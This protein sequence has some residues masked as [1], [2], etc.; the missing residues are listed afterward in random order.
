MRD[1]REE[2]VRQLYVQPS[3]DGY[4]AVKLP[5]SKNAQG[6]PQ[7]G[8][9]DA[10]FNALKCI[11]CNSTRQN[12]FRPCGENVKAVNPHSLDTT[13][14]PGH[15]KPFLKRSLPSL[16]MKYAKNNRSHKQKMRSACVWNSGIRS[17]G[18]HQQVTA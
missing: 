5:C 10:I 3:F 14:L 9:H 1:V 11:A 15:A 4:W 18:Y 7:V 8:K 2:K 13:A 17:N 16:A 6:E 12:V